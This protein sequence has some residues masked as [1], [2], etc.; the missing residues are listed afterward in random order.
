MGLTIHYEL[1]LPAS[2]SRESAEK[3]RE[4]HAFA[5]TQRFEKL[6]DL[7]LDDDVN[8]NT[9]SG[10][11][12]FFRFLASLVA[13]SFDGEASTIV[14]DPDTAMGFL[15]NPGQGCE[16]AG[17]GLQRRTDVIGKH[18]EWF[19]TGFCKTQYASNIAEEH[20]VAC[21]T[22]LVRLLEHAVVCGFEVVVEDEG[23]YWQTRDE[24]QLVAHVRGMNTL[25]AGVAGQFS[26]AFGDEH[27]VHAPIFEH[28]RFERLEMGESD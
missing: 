24:A 19:W 10:W 20:F 25:V 16:T 21:H 13:E 1:R 27:K 11:R 14:G 9:D 22:S 6:S 4:L 3:L 18:G 28:P 12:Q 17:F 15:V 5:T 23:Q 7:F 26:D 2:T 8:A